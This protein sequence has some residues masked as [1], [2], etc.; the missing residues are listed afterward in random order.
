MHLGLHLWNRGTQSNGRSGRSSRGRSRFLWCD[1]TRMGL[2]PSARSLYHRRLRCELL[3]D[4]SLLS[5]FTVANT[6]DGPVAHAGDLP[7]SL[8]QAVFD[9]NAAGGDNTINF[10]SSLAFGTIAL[11]AGELDLTN[12][13]G[14]T[15]ITGLDTPP[16]PIMMTIS[17]NTISRVFSVGAGV[18]VNITG[19]TIINATTSGSGGG[20]ENLGGNVT[21]NQCIILG[22]SADV[23]GGIANL[24]AG[25]VTIADT[26]IDEN[27]PATRGGG[28]DNEAGCTLTMTGGDIDQNSATTGGG[29][30]NLGTLTVTG[31]AISGNSASNG[32]GIFNDGT[33]TIA[34]STVSGN[35]SMSHGGGIDN[36][37]GTL[38]ITDSTISGN[39]GYSVSS[40]GGGIFN[41][42][43][44]TIA[45]S[46]ISGNSVGWCGGGI[47]NDGTLTIVDSTISGNR[48][49]FCGGIDNTSGTLTIAD[50][51][52]S[53]NT[54]YGVG[55]DADGGGIDNNSGTL[56]ITG[57]TIS[58]NSAETEG[59]S[60]ANGGGI[61][62]DGTLTI[63]DSTISGNR[64][65]SDIGYSYGGGICILGPGT[66]TAYDSTIAG[67]SAEHGGGIYSY[68][69]PGTLTLANTIVAA[70]TNMYG[71]TPTDVEGTVTASYSLIE[72][73]TGT[74]FSSSSA[75]NITGVDP[76]LGPLADNGGPTET[77][78]LLPGSPAIDA[79]DNA[80]I[81]SGVTTD[82]RGSGYPRIVNGTVDIGAYELQAAT[83]NVAISSN[84]PAG[85][86][87]GQ[88][89]VFTAMVSAAIGTPTGSVQFAID[90]SAYGSSVALVNGEASISVSGLS[91]TTHAIAASYSHDT[92]AYQDSSATVSYLVTPAPLLISADNQSK[93]YGKANPPLT[94]TVIG[95]V[96]G[97]ALTTPPAISTT[98]IT[99][100]H[101]G[102]YPITIGGAVDSNYIISYVD[103]TL[104][105]T[106]APLMVQADN[107]TYNYAGADGNPWPTFTAHAVAGL[108]FSDTLDSEG[109]TSQLKFST[110]ATPRSHVIVSFY[111]INVTGPGQAGD[112]D[113]TYLPGALTITPAA[114]LVF[115][116]N[117]AAMTYGAAL[118]PTL[119]YHVTGFLNGDSVAGLTKQPT[120][121]CPT[122][123]STSPAGT[124]S[125]VF[126]SPPA[127]PDYV[128][129]PPLTAPQ[130]VNGTLT[131]SPAR[132]LLFA[133]P[134]T[135]VYGA[136]TLPTLNYSVSGLVNGD[137]QSAVIATPPTLITTAKA[138]ILGQPESGSHVG[139]YAIH[140]GNA[141]VS[142]N[143]TVSYVANYVRVTPATLT[144]T[145]DNKYMLVGSALPPLTVSYAGFVNGDTA[146][147]L[148]VK[149]I[150]K[151]TATSAS[152]AGRYLITAG[153]AYDAD[154]SFKYKPGILTVEPTSNAVYLMP[155]PLSTGTP[156][157]NI[158]YIWGTAGNNSITVNPV[159][160]GRVSV[161]ISGIS[162]GAFGSDSQPISRIVAHGN[163][164]ADVITVSPNVDLPAWLYLDHGTGGTMNG[165]GG[166]T[167]EFGDPG[168]TLRGGSG[169]SILIG[170]TGSQR[171]Y[172]G[173]GD[174]ILIGG[175]TAYTPATPVD[176][177]HDAALL[178]ILSEWDSYYSSNPAI[179]YNTRVGHLRGTLAGGVN[180]PYYLR[181][182]TVF[183][184]SVADTLYGGP[185]ALD[186]FFRSVGDTLSGQRSGETTISV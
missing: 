136:A 88:T 171:L 34:G 20:I 137:T 19:L 109:I 57:S 47:F 131:I 167:Y 101:V 8:R 45:N 98:A 140:I 79:G 177:S 143:Y 178:A 89:V 102:S 1:A 163:G 94:Y 174:A 161:L 116:A 36:N 95:L 119:S 83:T 25:T 147:S 26:H 3:E 106:P 73:T 75:N 23:G 130:Y 112:Y 186:L 181:P 12:T 39:S 4:R 152:P 13:T 157:G 105:V 183:N 18:T 65:Y 78:A 96:P 169:P 159:L 103:G 30:R 61:F 53:G 55:S 10:D 149:P 6:S 74:I 29:I 122:A 44:L 162:K 104:T 14:T 142:S 170:G 60:L 115:T 185:T 176:T 40:D 5:V 21:I 59:G 133:N 70:N 99:A 72:N 15:T 93:V 135:M 52:I 128:I 155:D 158:L 117:N 42:G 148:A 11:S 27:S 168:A 100:S 37:S 126:T 32:G 67:N 48:G 107:K 118:L 139:S 46:T 86:I 38:T 56:T 35:S 153:G 51:T 123:G 76:L 31:T 166:P 64:A 151:T 87:Y 141:V 154:Y 180:G 134:A 138:A 43:T 125:I 150:A 63:T 7:G 85:S 84:Y 16:N 9:A 41:D 173:A 184:D 97:D 33:L 28:I 179:D 114:T 22:N 132:L 165:G 172:G 80:L 175:T 124:Y 145:A 120:L 71:Y 68:S 113:I 129:S 81:P 17:G 90:G 108:L 156:Q 111:P 91:A 121:A 160:P 50:S 62:N 164:G 182:G 92:L 146:A 110:T 54:A 82:Q 66:M 49:V 2:S 77:M 69:G 144:V 127:D 58:G 24:D